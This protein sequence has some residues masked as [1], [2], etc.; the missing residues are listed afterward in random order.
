[1]LQL[2]MQEETQHLLRDVEEDEM[3]VNKLDRKSITLKNLKLY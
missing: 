3:K 1:M 2:R